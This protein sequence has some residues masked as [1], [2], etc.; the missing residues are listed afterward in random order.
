MFR[1]K[2][3]ADSDHS[4]LSIEGD[5][6]IDGTELIEDE[7]TPALMQYSS[8]TIDMGEVM[9]V[10]SSGIGLLIKMIETLKEEGKTIKMKFIRPE[11][12]EVF[13]MLQ[14]QDIIGNEVFDN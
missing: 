6:D 5:I 14:I 9:F 7:I 3:S 2:L 12:N 13:E 4:M 11:V 8:V 1:Y 10:D